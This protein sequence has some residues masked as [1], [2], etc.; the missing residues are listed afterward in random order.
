LIID[1]IDTDSVNIKIK[2]VGKESVVG[3]TNTTIANESTSSG[4]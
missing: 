2:E 4:Y 3:T 1:S